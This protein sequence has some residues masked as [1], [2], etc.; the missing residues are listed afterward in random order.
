MK[1]ENGALWWGECFQISIKIDA[2]SVENAA[3]TLF[4]VPLQREKWTVLLGY[5]KPFPPRYT[6]PLN[7]V[8]LTD[9]ETHQ[10]AVFYSMIINLRDRGLL[11]SI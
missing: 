11:L 4:R 1:T 8:I 9:G 6:V 7:E 2:F 3:A 10:L 5:L